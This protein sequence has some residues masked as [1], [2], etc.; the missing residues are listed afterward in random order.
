M[1]SDLVKRNRELEEELEGLRSERQSLEAKTAT[2]EDELKRVATEREYLQYQIDKFRHMLFGKSSEKISPRSDGTVQLE[3]LKEA[4]AEIET[5]EIGERETLTYER[6]KRRARRKPAEDL[7]RERIEIDVDRDLRTC[8]DCGDEMSPIGED[9]SE[10]LEYIPALLYIIEYAL[11]KYACRKCQTGVV[12]AKRPPRPLPKSRPGVDLLAYLLVSKYQD[13]LPLHC[14][15]RIFARHGMA[16]S[17]KTL[18]DWVH[19]SAELLRPIADAMK[20]EV[21]SA[22][23]V[24]A[25]E[26]PVEVKNPEVKGRT[27]KG[28]IWTYGIPEREVVYDFS[29]GRSLASPIEFLDGYSGYLQSD[30]YAVYKSLEKS[31]QTVH[32]GCWSHARRGFY[33]SRAEKPEFAD[34]VLAA[35]QRLF[36]LERVA[37]EKQITGEA[38]VKLRRA[39]AQP[40]LEQLRQL[41]E[42]KRPYVLPKA[43]IGRAISYALNNWDALTRYVDIPEA[44]PHNNSAE[45]S[46]RGVVLGRKNWLFI[47]HPNAGP[48][49]AIILSLIESAH[50]LGA[51]SYKYL[52]SVIAELAKSPERAA[53]LTPRRWLESQRSAS[54][55]NP[56]PE[57]AS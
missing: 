54:T 2:L 41:L 40:V 31:G 49:A 20:R 16:L 6:K 4:K 47:G 35:I 28:W 29:M 13:H 23:L 12:Q 10:E 14:L 46:V 44:P 42:T 3:F 45:R 56:A 50:R 21:L 36:R 1:I 27:S 53:E 9:I 57:S 33:E 15:E 7:H 38:L 32:V 30:S 26:P 5:D 48:R 8:P 24:Q 17:R 11:K 37:K 51:D 52:H 39:E 34:L 19:K 25:D 43:G 55:K 18:C 22:P